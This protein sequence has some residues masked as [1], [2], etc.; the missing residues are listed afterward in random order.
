MGS[1]DGGGGGGGGLCEGVVVMVVY[2]RE[3]I[4]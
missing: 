4:I 3:Y 1:G 2:C